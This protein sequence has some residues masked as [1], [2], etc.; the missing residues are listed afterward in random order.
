MNENLVERFGR[1]RRAVR[2][3]N[4]Q[5]EVWILPP[6]LN[7]KVREYFEDSKRPIDGGAW[8]SRPA[9]PSSA[10]ILD[11]DIVTTSSADVVEI[12]PN[13]PK[14]AWESKGYHQPQA[15][16][17]T[18]YELLRED[19]V[20]PLRLAVSRVRIT[21]DGNE[22]TFNGAVGIYE[23]VHICGM[24]CATRGIAL[25]VTFSLGRVGKKIRWD[26]SKRL[27][28]GGLVVLTPVKDMFQ[29]R[30]IVATVAA[31]PL[32]L[33]DLN[34]PEIDL[35]IA[36]PEEMEIDP[37]AEWV[38]VEDR[39]G[40]Y[41]ADKHTLLALQR[42]MREPFPLAE[43]LVD[44]QPIVTAPAYVAEQPKR[45]LTSVL[46]NNKHATYENVD[47]LKQWPAQPSSDM[48]ASQLAALRRILTKRLAVI[49]GPPGTGK[50]YVSEQAIKIMLANRKPDDPPIIIACQTNHAVDQL[51]RKIAEFE[52]E[53]VRLGGRSKD[54]EVIKKRTL[55][56]VRMLTSD[57][58]LAG[59]LKG[60]A[61][62]KMKDLEKEFGV[63]L[64]P[65]KPEK[66]PLDFT[67]LEKLG[68]LTPKQASSLE[69]GASR[70]VQDKRSNPNEAR[71]SPFNVWLGKTLVSVPLKQQGE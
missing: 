54:K 7:P 48:D 18:Q 30:A 57:E 65:L 44:A 35:Y 25:R 63:L 20:Q 45:D 69:F 6:Q 28:T 14:G 22:E 2:P 16:L 19:A 21:P 1:S 12:V 66:T 13:K 23:K 3:E 31:R 49:Q 64:S 9:V 62:K 56:E 51:L 38:M 59:S 11:T 46:R 8:V 36:R 27:I 5:A 43:H 55:Y 67:M 70:W 71:S 10:E 33:L 37:A 60:N 24:T 50:T 26:Q 4:E 52:K 34:P 40:F 39:S 47:I 68:L 32:E 29:T 42:M 41:E 58:Q 17:S 15:Y 53:F 61:R